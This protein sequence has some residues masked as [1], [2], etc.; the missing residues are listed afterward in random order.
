MAEQDP[1]DKIT[2][3]TNERNEAQSRVRELEGVSAR[4]DAL[5]GSY[6]ALQESSNALYRRFRQQAEAL[7]EAKIDAENADSAR[8][9]AEA[10]LEEAN[11]QVSTLQEQ[12]EHARKTASDYVDQRDK[13]LDDAEALELAYRKLS[14]EVSAA[15]GRFQKLL[16][17]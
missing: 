17:N 7:K 15:I 10:A 2:E 9:R 16:G 13:A 11:E 12:L 6:S 5:N 4:L 3:L 1:Y 8:M 14:D